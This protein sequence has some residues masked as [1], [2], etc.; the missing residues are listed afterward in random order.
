MKTMISIF[1]LSAALA[2]TPAAA[3]NAGNQ[4]VSIQASGGLF[5]PDLEGGVI[6]PTS[7]SGT[8]LRDNFS[9][10]FD[11]TFR[12]LSGDSAYSLWWVVFNEPENCLFGCDVRD[13]FAG[14]GQVF[15]GGGFVTDPSGQGD[16][17]ARTTIGEIPDGADR[18]SEVAPI[19]FDPPLIIDPATETG[20]QNPHGAMIHVVVRYHGT[21]DAANV[22]GQIG[23]YLGGCALPDGT[24]GAACFDEQ[25]LVFAP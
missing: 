14:H 11:G 19:A 24:P 7:S 3:K 21:V 9:L 4:D 10:F 6:T 18:F 16:V 15:Y 1:A 23:T 22:A 12:D 25:I 8:L 20:L 13:L 2:A 5:L 17:S